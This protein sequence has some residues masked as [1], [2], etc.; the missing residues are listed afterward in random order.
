MTAVHT[1]RKQQRNVLAFLTDAVD[2][3]SRHQA[4]PSLLP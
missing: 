2:A 3:A 1:L 4:S